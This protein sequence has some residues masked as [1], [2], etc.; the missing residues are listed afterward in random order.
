MANTTRVSVP[1]EVGEEIVVRWNGDD[2]ITYKVTDNHV[3]VEN[4]NVERFFSL[5]EG[6][7][8]ID[9]TKADARAS[10]K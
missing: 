7:K 5:F 4:E 6:S 9:A 3:T 1:K 8:V 10:A 2:P